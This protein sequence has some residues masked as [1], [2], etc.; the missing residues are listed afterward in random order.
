MRVWLYRLHYYY[1]NDHQPTSV[2]EASYGP[3]NM[4]TISNFSLF[5][6]SLLFKCSSFDTLVLTSTSFSLNSDSEASYQ[7]QNLWQWSS[8]QIR[9]NK[10]S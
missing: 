5:P 4:S 8:Q 6:F 1:D 10:K 9:D 7:G 2:H 3:P